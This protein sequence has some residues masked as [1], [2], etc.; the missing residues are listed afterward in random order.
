MC[1]QWMLFINLTSHQVSWSQL[2]SKCDNTENIFMTN[3]HCICKHI[4]IEPTA[5][6]HCGPSLSI[7]S[8]VCLDGNTKGASETSGRPPIFAT[9]P[10]YF[11]KLLP[12][13]VYR[14][15]FISKL[16]Q[17][18]Q[19]LLTVTVTDHTSFGFSSYIFASK[20]V[21]AISECHLSPFQIK[22]CGHQKYCTKVVCL[23][24]RFQG[25]GDSKNCTQ[26]KSICI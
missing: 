16:Y 17:P 11:F 5:C 23:C 24:L 9:D 26:F 14:C 22:F 21:C 15:V 6:W 12:N 2:K 18:Y 10:H 25:T 19:L 8:R 20:F 1:L 3:T 13:G 4:S 7:T